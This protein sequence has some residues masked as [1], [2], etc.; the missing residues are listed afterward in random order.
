MKI[1]FIQ[2]DTFAHNSRYLGIIL[3]S[4]VIGILI[5]YQYQ[6]YQK[7]SALISNRDS[8][9]S[10]FE[11]ID[12]VLR[13]NQNLKEEIEELGEENQQYSDQA[14]A[15]EAL[16]KEIESMKKL[17][18]Y[19]NIRGPGVVVEIDKP[20]DLVW[21]IDLTNELFSMGAEAVSINGIRLVDSNM[22]FYSLPGDQII[23]NGVLLNSPYKIE[24][25]G[26]PET[27]MRVLSQGGGII[28]RLRSAFPE[29]SIDLESKEML[30]IK[31]V[32]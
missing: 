9:T 6:S 20:V 24:G 13:T 7:V 16:S 15:A 18:G 14:Q 11:E 32:F 22:S 30:E 31:K 27:M 29:H 25:I 2:K 28:V 5:S 17:A 19:T 4:V 3:T 26:D 10:F 12:I 8:T 21:F 23:L 1:T